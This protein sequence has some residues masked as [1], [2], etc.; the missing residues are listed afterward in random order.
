MRKLRVLGA[1]A[2]TLSAMGFAVGD[3]VA[4]QQVDR[5]GDRSWRAVS[6]TAPPPAF[7]TL[8]GGGAVI[9]VPSGPV[10]GGPDPMQAPLPGT[11]GQGGSGGVSTGMGKGRFEPEPVAPGRN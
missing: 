10:G 3:Q 5:A 9:V 6:P 11:I 8:P 1:L 7:P 4:A 2:V